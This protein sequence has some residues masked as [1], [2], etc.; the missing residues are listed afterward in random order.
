[1]ARDDANLRRAAGDHA[2]V[3]SEEMR[4]ETVGREMATTC[5]QLAYAG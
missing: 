5:D 4:P 1:M 3:A 2:Q